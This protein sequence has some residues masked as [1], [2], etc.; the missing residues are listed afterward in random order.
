LKKITVDVKVGSREEGV[1]DLGEGR[2]L[3]KVKAPKKKGKA[4]SAVLKLLQRHFGCRATMVSGHTSTRKIIE[5]E[6]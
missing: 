2:Y 3:V 4:N 1:E 6:E 5:L